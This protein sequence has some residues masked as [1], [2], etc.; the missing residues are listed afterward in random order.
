MVSLCIGVGHRRMR[1][2]P[3]RRPLGAGDRRSRRALGHWI[4]IRDGGIMN[5]PCMTLPRLGKIR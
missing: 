3:S 4:V 1:L 5:Y 2:F